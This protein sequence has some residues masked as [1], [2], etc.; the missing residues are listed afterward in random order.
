LDLDLDVDTVIRP[1]FALPNVIAA[2]ERR[3]VSTLENDT[4]FVPLDGGNRVLLFAR[5]SKGVFFFVLTPGRPRTGV[6]LTI[7]GK[8]FGKSSLLANI[9]GCY[10]LDFVPVFLQ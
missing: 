8:A 3:F 5:Q 7:D 10:P 1:V 4:C 2:M 9:Q 6:T